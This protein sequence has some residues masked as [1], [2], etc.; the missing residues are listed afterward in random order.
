MLKPKDQ[1]TS[2]RA[3]EMILGLNLGNDLESQFYYEGHFWQIDVKTC[4]ESWHTECQVEIILVPAFFYS[5]LRLLLLVSTF[6]N[7]IFIR[8]IGDVWCKYV[9][10]GKFE[11]PSDW[12]LKNKQ[13]SWN[14][15]I[16]SSLK[17]CL[18]WRRMKRRLKK[19]LLSIRRWLERRWRWPRCSNLWARKKVEET[20]LKRK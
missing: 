12:E 7:E 6:H 18:R 14:R 15:N 2:V 10:R 13:G 8:Y 3:S 5:T 11:G 4:K 9:E 17:L 19:S 1:G 16:W 20:S